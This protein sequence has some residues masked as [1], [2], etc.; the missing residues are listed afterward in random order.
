MS[1]HISKMKTPNWKFTTRL[2]P[3]LQA[4]VS[5]YSIDLLEITDSTGKILFSKLESGRFPDGD[6]LREISRM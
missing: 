4:L 6:D 1:N 2:N 5:R 3:A